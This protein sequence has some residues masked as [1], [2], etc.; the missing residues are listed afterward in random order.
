MGGFRILVILAS[1][2]SIKDAFWA[3][4]ASVCIDDY[5]GRYVLLVFFAGPC[6]SFAPLNFY[7]RYALLADIQFK[8]ISKIYLT[9]LGS[10]LIFRSVNMIIDKQQL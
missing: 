7:V 9:T 10:S 3:I 5:S 6:H 1:L 4:E 2:D 8:E